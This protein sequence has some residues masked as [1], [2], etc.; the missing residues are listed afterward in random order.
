MG[1]LRTICKHSNMLS[2]KDRTTMMYCG[3]K[4]NKQIKL[5]IKGSQNRACPAQLPT[6]WTAFYCCHII[7]SAFRPAGVQSEKLKPSDPQPKWNEYG[8]MRP[9]TRLHYTMQRERE[10]EYTWILLTLVKNLSRALNHV[11][12]Y[13]GHTVRKNAL[14]YKE[15]TYMHVTGRL[16]LLKVPSYS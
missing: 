1:H 3:C 10:T 8:S 12:F 5:R 9:E 13:S 11:Y 6:A 16:R 2:S 14:N 15:T 4:P 7:A